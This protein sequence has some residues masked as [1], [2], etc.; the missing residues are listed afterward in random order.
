[1]ENTYEQALWLNV[2]NTLT[3]G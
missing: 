2:V 3:Y 1:M